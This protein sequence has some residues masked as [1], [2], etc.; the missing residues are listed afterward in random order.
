MD[1]KLISVIIRT[2]ITIIISKKWRKIRQGKTT[3]TTGG[4]EEPVSENKNDVWTAWEESEEEIWPY[5][6]KRQMLNFSER[7]L[8][9]LLQAT[10]PKSFLMTQVALN[11][12]IQVEGIRD[13]GTK[14]SYFGKISQ[15]S[16]D[17]LICDKNA[18]PIIAI[19]LDGPHHER[20][21][22]KK[23]DRTKDLALAA[24]GIKV[25]RIKAWELDTL[26]PKELLK[27]LTA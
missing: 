22:Q 27:R 8:Y 16:L 26:T 20:E 21:N 13:Y 14:M 5:Q 1:N 3:K 24:A 4:R 23:A 12:V 19:E 6:A 18:K 2:I 17:F 25:V 11:Q 7:R 10:L 15:K 9:E